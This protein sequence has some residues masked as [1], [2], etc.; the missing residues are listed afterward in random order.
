LRKCISTAR[1]F[2]ID[3]DDCICDVVQVKPPRTI[4][5]ASII[6]STENITVETTVVSEKISAQKPKR[7]R[8]MNVL[9][10]RRCVSKNGT[11]AYTYPFLAD[12]L[13]GKHVRLPNQLLTT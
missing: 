6:V 3:D 5:E 7:Q 11:H 10:V 12:Q 1:N 9:G 2:D 13:N 4:T 8:W